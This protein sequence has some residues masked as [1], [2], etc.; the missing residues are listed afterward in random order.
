MQHVDCNEFSLSN[1]S[2]YHFRKTYQTQVIDYFLKE[3]IVFFCHYFLSSLQT[4]FFRNRFS[5]NII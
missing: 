5:W 4:L 1:K 3:R 2:I